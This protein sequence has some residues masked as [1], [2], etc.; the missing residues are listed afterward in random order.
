M[1]TATLELDSAP[2]TQAALDYQ[3]IEKA[4]LYLQ[5]HF[6]DQPDLTQVASAVHLS[7]FHFQRL[8]SRWAGI[9]PKRFLQFLTVEHAKRQLADFKPVL[10]VALDSGL[11]SPGRLHDLFV[12]VDAVSP[13]EFKSRGAGL[14]I[15]YGIHPTPFGS[16]LLGVTRR[17]LCWL[18]FLE[19]E[20][21]AQGVAEMKEHWS[22]AAFIE[23]PEAAA[24]VVARIFSANPA[25]ASLPLNL[26]V[27]GTNFQVKVWQA[28]LNIPAGAVASYDS[29]GKLIGAPKSARAIGAAVGQ[30]AIAYL[31]PC[32][33][34]IRNTGLLGGYRWGEARKQII[35][36]WETARTAA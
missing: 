21:R 22:G 13:G 35:L 8:F 30:N 16:C 15:E 19:N 18:S 5:K 24:A 32:H 2:L 10:D 36:A 23:C 7:E 34:I 26:L 31:I 29:I 33:R 3:R 20:K 9:S 4:I 6:L 11:S 1:S 25:P 27:M 14:T 28:L 12:S 17:G